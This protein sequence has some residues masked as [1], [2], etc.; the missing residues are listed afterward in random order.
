MRANDDIA[1]PRD[2]DVTFARR[3]ER[4]NLKMSSGEV[5]MTGEKN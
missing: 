5:S 3:P 2:K 4:G 1:N